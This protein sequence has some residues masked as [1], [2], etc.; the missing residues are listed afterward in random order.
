MFV[1]LPTGFLVMVL[2]LSPSVMVSV[3]V[4]EVQKNQCL[5]DEEV[6]DLFHQR[7]DLMIG[8]ENP[9][10][11]VVAEDPLPLV[12]LVEQVHDQEVAEDIPHA[13]QE[14][15]EEGDRPHGLQGV[16][17][18]GEHPHGRWGVVEEVDPRDLQVVVEEEELQHAL[19]AEVVEEEVPQAL[20]VEVGVGVEE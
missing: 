20:Q 18:E 19:Q 7:G 4:S 16:V 14:V 1:A 9:V 2:L 10:H 17:G 8:L 15:A 13:H 11:Q 6:H 3:L 5:L 12:E